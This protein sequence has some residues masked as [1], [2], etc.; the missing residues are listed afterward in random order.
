MSAFGPFGG[1][2]ELPFYEL[3]TNG[4]FLISGDTG[5]GKTTIFDGISFAL[6]GNASGESR[7]SDAFRSDYA[8]GEIKTFVTLTFLHKGKEY[9]VTRNPS[10]QRAKKVGEGT[11]EE[12]ANAT[13]VLPEGT[14][15]TG[16]NPVTTKIVE[17]LGIDWA[18]YKQIAMIAQGEFMKL[19][20][21]DSKERGPIFR[22]VFGT[23]IYDNIQRSLKRMSLDLGNQCLAI[24]K[25]ILQYLEGIVCEE[26]HPHYERIQLFK[27]EKNIHETQVILDL[28]T[29]IL[30]EDKEV[31]KELHKEKSQ[32][33]SEIM[34]TIEEYQ[35]AKLTNQK[36][37]DLDLANE[38]KESLIQKQE[39]MTLLE[40][41]LKASKNALYSVKPSYDAY[42]REEKEVMQI[43]SSIITLE[44]K[45][46]LL[47]EQLEK[48]RQRKESVENYPQLCNELSTEIN[49]LIEEGNKF[50]EMKGLGEQLIS[51][52]N[53]FEKAH[54]TQR[55]NLEKK[56]KLLL[57]EEEGCKEDLRY[58]NVEQNIFTCKEELGN[59]K[60]L[61]KHLL[62]LRLKME[63]SI[64]E[65][66]NLLKKQGVFLAAEKEYEEA[67][68]IFQEA[69]KLY[70]R[71]QAGILAD[72]L[73]EN[74]PCPVCG[75]TIH[76]KKAEKIVEAPTEA[77]LESFKSVVHRKNKNLIEQSGIVKEHKS[78]CVFLKEQ[79]LSIARELFG[80][81][82]EEISLPG[83]IE[84]AVDEAK[85]KE[86]GLERQLLQYNKE[87]IRK[88]ELRK[89]RNEIKEELNKIEKMLQIS[90][91]ELR[92]KTEEITSIKATIHTIRNSLQSKDLEKAKNLLL[93]KKNQ[94]EE[95]QKRYQ[96]ILEAYA[97]CEKEWIRNSTALLENKQQLELRKQTELEAEEKL[98]D[99]LLQAGFLT[100]EDF[101][102]VLL[103]EHEINL[104]A[105]EFSQY[106]NELLHIKEKITTLEK[107]LNDKKLV[108]LK[109]M[110]LLQEQ[111]K[112]QKKML[113]D[114]IKE[115]YFRVE[116]N[117]MIYKNAR[118]KIGEQEQV[119]KEYLQVN[120][121]SNTANGELRGKAKIPFEQYVQAFYFN[122]VIWEANKRLYKMT[123]SQYELRKKEEASD[124]R[125]VT[126]LELEVMDY[127][128]GKTRSV[129]SLSGGESFK[130]SLSLALGLS[131]VIQSYAGGIELD[132]MFIDEGFGSLD[133]N[134]LDQAIDTLISL[135]AGNRFVGIISHV[136]ELKER[137][138]KQIILSK[139]MEG[140]SVKIHT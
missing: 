41:K 13:L 32:L 115:I 19:L 34:R 135:S 103:P 54:I 94:Y 22:K 132:A 21:A 96:E 24:D 69:E 26:D 133:S 117:D 139:S 52:T 18:Q 64:A 58:E 76:P 138:E 112:Y 140:S 4:L 89:R 75:S 110:E 60:Q 72:K 113:E 62:E 88:D 130:A 128:T 40:E 9:Q 87:F 99:C 84:R 25:S 8:K 86:S 114:H 121:L 2:V 77:E 85:M 29:A 5:A 35:E 79:I 27:K 28:L 108:D 104:M 101:T 53:S 65:E 111:Q 11:T 102:K 45:Q 129:K 109:E 74:E 36:F 73:M 70:Y 57:E 95:L 17:L 3:G 61:I 59:Q 46:K 14:V 33:D 80:I 15:I 124:N 50:E 43:T 49:R 81:R 119:R 100:L 66:E 90:F 68:Q 91:E 92:Q 116:N 20:N 44:E 118:N 7:S 47:Q 125:I 98:K 93:D 136:N 55:I 37:K 131:D 120:E 137:I 48:A 82:T 97:H 63:Q 106:K 105:E 30:E 122:Q 134:S 1:L 126:G 51:F 71:E 23:Y 67:Y 56:E 31:Y 78:K 6:F 12:K 123:N 39:E 10:Y 38:K 107:E 127:Y 42:L 16:A 83:L